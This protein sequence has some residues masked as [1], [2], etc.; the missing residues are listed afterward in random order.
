MRKMATCKECIHHDV[1]TFADDARYQDD[2]C[3]HCESY[4]DKSR[5]IELP[6]KV[7]DTVYYFKGGYYLGDKNRWKITPI[8]VTEFSIKINRSGKVLPLS[9]IA[10]GTR[11]AISSIGKIVFLTREEAEK[12]LKE[13]EIK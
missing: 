7:G 2:I 5:Y 6:C 8:K 11:Y 4:K 1:C 13:R 9:I 12:A 3:K 10:N